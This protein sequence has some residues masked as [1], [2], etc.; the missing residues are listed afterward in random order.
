MIRRPPR[1]PLFPYTTLFRSL[2]LLALRRAWLVPVAAVVVGLGLI[3]AGLRI[4]TFDDEHPRQTRLVY[5]LDADREQAWWL[6]ADPDPAPWSERYV[7][8]GRIVT[9]ARFPDSASLSLA[10]RYHAG[11]ASV[12]RI[13][14]P[15]VTVTRSKRGGDTRSLE[16]RITSA[17]AS[18]LALYAD[19]KA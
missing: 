2:D 6:S 13:E 4:D 11:P 17:E 16:L 10:S 9:G 12:A 19:T 15:E 18:R 14:P 8:T 5:A 3:A 1:S 7:D